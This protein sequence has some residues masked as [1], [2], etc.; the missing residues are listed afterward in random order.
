MK[1]FWIESDNQVLANDAIIFI[2]V[3][4]AKESV[5]HIAERRSCLS[6]K[7]GLCNTEVK[8]IQRRTHTMHTRPHSYTL[9]LSANSKHLVYNCCMKIQ[10]YTLDQS[11]GSKY[12]KRY[13]VN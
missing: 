3:E 9:R 4:N 12:T 8:S 5:H 10:I 2:S 1:A 11:I 6:S 13:V 7:L